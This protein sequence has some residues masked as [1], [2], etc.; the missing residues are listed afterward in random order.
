MIETREVRMNVPTGVQ[1]EDKK[2]KVMVSGMASEMRPK[3]VA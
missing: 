2:C 1:L 3:F